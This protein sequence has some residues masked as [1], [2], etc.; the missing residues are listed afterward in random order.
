[1]NDRYEVF[2]YLLKKVVDSNITNKLEILERMIDLEWE[3]NAHWTPE[4]IGMIKNSRNA[5]II[6]EEIVNEDN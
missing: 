5:P 6:L 1:M 4:E 2:L 3:K